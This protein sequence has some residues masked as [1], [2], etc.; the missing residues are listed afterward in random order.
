[1]QITAGAVTLFIAMILLLVFLVLYASQVGRK[2]QEP[3]GEV[4]SGNPAMER[5]V[6]AVLAMLIVS[7]LLLVGYGI[8]EPV[9]QAAA[10]DRQE[11]ISMQRGIEA[12]TTL[13]MSCH[14]IDGGG[15]V[16]PDSSPPRVA[17]Q[18]NRADLRPTDPDEYK[19]RYEFVYKTIA[20]GRPGTPMPAWGKQDGGTL[21]DEHI[22]ELALLI[23][24]GDKELQH[25][26]TAWEIAREHALEKVAHGSPEPVVPE[27]QIAA[28]LTDEEK[29][30]AR[31][32]QG[33]GACIGCHAI[34]GVGGATGPNQSQ[35]GSIAPTRVP[36]QS[37]E[38]YMRSSILQPSTYLVPGF[39]PV[40]PS[41]QGLLTDQELSQLVAYLLTL[42]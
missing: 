36:G 28:D 12:Y 11:R 37:A 1:M 15:A 16:V 39:P 14:G 17:P 9:R 19:A 8:W 22:Y 5:K 38:E 27:I 41:Y 13:C 2:A 29:A 42:R 25:G 10:A 26:D 34:G 31:I 33:K 3:V 23:T 40:M 4:P 6:V 32:W 18:L 24:K 21:L 7:G 35:M 30:G 20:R